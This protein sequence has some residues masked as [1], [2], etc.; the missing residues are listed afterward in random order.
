[1]RAIFGVVGLLMTLFIV[2]WL[3]GGPTGP[4]GKSQLEVIADA[5][6]TAETQAHG[7]SGRD[8]QGRRASE[9]LT[10]ELVSGGTRTTGIRVAAIEPGSAL[11]AKYKLLAGDVILEIGPLPASEFTSE[12]D[13]AAQL[14]DAFARTMPLLVRRGEQ[15]L[16]LAPTS[17]GGIPGLVPTH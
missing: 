12:Q 5:K 17:S 6:K 9:A 15:K 3:M 14:D 4:G 10:L 16:T 13:A 1:M 2:L 11:A 7:F 8:Q